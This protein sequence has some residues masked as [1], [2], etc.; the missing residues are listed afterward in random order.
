MYV[1]PVLFSSLRIGDNATRSLCGN[2]KSK[3]AVKKKFTT[4]ILF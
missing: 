4:A 2:E 1:L 3:Q